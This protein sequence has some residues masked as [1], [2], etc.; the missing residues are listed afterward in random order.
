MP[1]RQTGRPGVQG[2]RGRRYVAAMK[3]RVFVTRHVYPA[4]IAILQE[5]CIV[6]Y[7][8]SHDVIDE[9][10][11]G[12]R[13]QHAHGVVCQLTDPLNKNVID[14]APHLRVIAQIAVGHD[15]VDVPAAT[16][17]GIV[18]TNTPG[19][20]D[21]ATADLTFALL[22]AAAR[23]LPE[24]ERFL[25]DGKW[26]RWDVDLLCGSDVHE[27]CIGI[28]GL[29]RIGR[30][31]A[32][33]ARGFSMR[34]LYSGPRP[35]PA[36]V[37]QELQARHVPL[38][39]LLQQSDFVSVHV[40]LRADTHHL[41][42]VEQLSR[43]K[44]SAFLINTSRGPVVDELALVAAL[45][46]GLLAGAGLDVFEREPAVPAGLL[47]LPNVVLLPHVASATVS[48]RTLMCALAAKNCAAVLRGE[49]PP[50]PVNP[51]VLG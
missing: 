3:P 49:R 47:A 41:I 15:N 37:E 22:L 28:V 45:E 42:G 23:R 27:R 33:R 7:R 18:V 24:A 1:L 32:R 31:V 2:R 10:Q 38:D 17:R 13:L 20:L 5:D 12:K 48:V 8:D 4:A 6:D 30:A 29:G 9:A 46:E 50:H 39:A 44:R 34:V 16:A 25:R 51:E 40:P 36:E 21:E 35:A 26:Q 14:A 19:V 43:M 11:L